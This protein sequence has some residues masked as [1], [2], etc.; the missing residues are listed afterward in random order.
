[1]IQSQIGD[2]VFELLTNSLSIRELR[3]NHNH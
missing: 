3:M 1:M 2:S